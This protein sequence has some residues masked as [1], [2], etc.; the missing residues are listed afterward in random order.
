MDNFENTSENIYQPEA[1][2]QQEKQPGGKIV[3]DRNVK[4]PLIVGLIIQ[5]IAVIIGLGFF[6][7]QN[8]L[9]NTMIGTGAENKKTIFPLGLL[10]IIILLILHIITFLVI[11]T[12]EGNNRRMVEIFLV[13]AYCLRGL[14]SVGFTYLVNVLYYARLGVETIAAASAINN[15]YSIIVTPICTISIFMVIIAIGRYGVSK[16]K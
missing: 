5:G 6:V 7:A 8:S 12:Y 13:A 11:K 15:L 16:V 3:I 1:A 10:S 2:P 4:L 9:V 14:L